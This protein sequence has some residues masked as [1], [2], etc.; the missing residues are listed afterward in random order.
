MNYNFHSG[1]IVMLRIRICISFIPV[2]ITELYIRLDNLAAIFEANSKPNDVQCQPL[3]IVFV[4]AVYNKCAEISCFRSDLKNNSWVSLHHYAV[5]LDGVN[6]NC[7]DAY[8]VVE[9]ENNMKL[10]IF[11]TKHKANTYYEHSIHYDSSPPL[12]C[13]TSH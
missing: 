13:T 12:K 10:H 7:T 6:V 3:T 5:N 9:W 8:A 11:A 4:C 1:Y 2:A